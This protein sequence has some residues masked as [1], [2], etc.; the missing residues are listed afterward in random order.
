MANQIFSVLKQ[1]L[2]ARFNHR[3]D[4]V[5]DRKRSAFYSN[6]IDVGFLR[7]RW[8][9]DGQ[10]APD[11]FRSNHPDEIRFKAYA[12]RGIRTVV[13]LRNDV[14]RAPSKFSEEFSVS[15]GMKYVNFPML[16]RR[17]PTRDE[18]QGLIAMFNT[19]EKPIL[20]HCKSGAD[21]TGLV[22]AIWLLTQENSLLKDAR[23]E[24]SLKYIHRRD[25]ETGV[26]DQVLDAYEPFESQ[27]DFETWLA[28]KYDPDD[29][30]KL[31]DLAKPNRSRWQTVRHFCKDVYTYAQHREFVWHESFAKEITSDEDRK[32]ANFFM[33]WIDHGVLRSFWT[34]FH[35][36][37]PGYFR[38]NHPT[39]KRFKQYSEQGF[40]TVINLRGASMQPQYQ[41]EKTLCDEL[42]LKLI[43]IEMEG[44]QAPPRETVLALLDA[45][46]TAEKPMLVHCKSG[47]DRTGLAAALLRLS[48]GATVSEAKQELSLRYLH[49]KN[50]GKGVLG[51]IIDQYATETASDPLSVRTWVMTKYDPAPLTKG[52]H[53]LRK[54]GGFPA[55]APVAADRTRMKKIAVITSVRND[56]AFLSRWI[57]YYGN[58][59]GATSLFVILDGFDQPIPNAKGV[60]FIRV[61]FVQK[62]VVAGD[63]SRAARASNLAQTLFNTFDIVIGTDVDEFIAVD[64]KLNLSLPEY[65]SAKHLTAPLSPLGL[66]VAQH[67]SLE[68]AIK[69]DRPF[70][71]QRQFA[72]ISDRY[73]KASILN[74]PHQWGSGY[75]RVRGQNFEID[76]NLF[77]FHFGSVD[78]HVSQERTVDEDRIA[79]GWAAHQKRRD[80]LFD[81]ITDADP[82]DGDLRF[83][84]A[85]V[86]MA[87]KRPLHAWNKPGPLKDKAIVRIP[88]RF[89]D[90]F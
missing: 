44:G 2:Y 6:W 24:L 25:S 58:S 52:F 23:P 68:T 31:A 34:N 84:S 35:E 17:V 26:L 55:V 20:F 30:Q 18:L 28:Q 22:A 70:L 79:E 85:R 11:V 27:M 38:S 80:A 83:E 60:N 48:H 66:D 74:A 78:Q 86:E 37:E 41:L 3:I 47:A 67:L 36:I 88:D 33:R 46:E 1:R 81:E 87:Q 71:E 9:N 42:N 56:T 90:L 77:L 82:V 10:V 19:L 21:R 53:A 65:L 29:A 32:R 61:P 43:D 14:E 8:T 51:W 76:P 39:E 45:Y 62:S 50:G 5:E 59:L 72:K 7:H 64:P 4:N 12:E 75:H 15:N 57:E 16:P 69:K 63:K 54:H 73:T 89:K 13:N 40:K 49:L